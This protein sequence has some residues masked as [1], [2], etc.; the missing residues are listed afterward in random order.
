MLDSDR[1]DFL[2]CVA[3]V[4]RKWNLRCLA[5]CLMSNHWHLLLWPEGDYDLSRYMHWLTTTHAAAWRRRTRTTGNGA[6]YQS[7]FFALPMRIRSTS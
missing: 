2:E 7:R 5:Y 4:V 1:A 6:I 3:R